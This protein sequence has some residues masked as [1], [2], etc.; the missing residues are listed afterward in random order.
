MKKYV[1]LHEQYAPNILNAMSLSIETGSPVNPPIW[2]VD[3]SD[4]TAQSIDDGINTLNQIT[5][6]N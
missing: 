6:D 3:P 4:T 5:L 2:W 1:D